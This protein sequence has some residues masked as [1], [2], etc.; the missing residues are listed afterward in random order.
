MSLFPFCS[1]V[2]EAA[3]SSAIPLVVDDSELIG[4]AEPSPLVW[5]DKAPFLFEVPIDTKS[6]HNSNKIQLHLTIIEE[7]ENLWD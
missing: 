3:L 7:I 4:K 2:A 1:K 5:P 6:G